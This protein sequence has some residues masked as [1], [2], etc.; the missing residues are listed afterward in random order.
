MNELSTSELDGRLAELGRELSP[1]L[2]AAH[3]SRPIRTD[4][5]LRLETHRQRLHIV[6]QRAWTGLAAGL[7][8]GVGLGAAAFMTR[9]QPA[10]AD[11]LDKLEAEAFSTGLSASGPGC[12]PAPGSGGE[13]ARSTGG[14]IAFQAGDPVSGPPTGPTTMTSAT[15]L[16][17]KLAKALGVSGDK[18]RAAMVATVRANLPSGSPPDPLAKIAENLGVSRDQ[19]CAAFFDPQAPDQP[20]ITGV[21]AGP[22]PNKPDNP[23]LPGAVTSF[24]GHVLD[25]TSP[26][27]DQLKGPAAK[28]GVTTDR[29]A[30][31]VKAAAPPAPPP[32]PN[33]DEIIKRFAQNLG[34]SE[35]TV[36]A[37]IKQVEG[38]HG[39]Y[40]AVPLPG[41]GK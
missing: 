12:P 7:A 31:A 23:D 19:V 40:F 32:L 41:F 36:R 15:D 39:F 34:M 5:G 9:P 1:A 3:R 13:E 37:A 26:T 10:A 24:N 29:L 25:L 8:G 18:V 14:I 4:A 27:P 21:S 16:S 22:G 20:V 35:D 28:L 30:E 6:R 17:D 38:D 11:V 2:R 33:P